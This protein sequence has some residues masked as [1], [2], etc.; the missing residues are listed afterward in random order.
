MR[1]KTGFQRSFFASWPT[2]TPATAP[3]IGS[4]LNLR[5]EQK[6][7]RSGLNKRRKNKERRSKRR[8]RR[9]SKFHFRKFF[10][11]LPSQSSNPTTNGSRR[12]RNRSG[13]YTSDLS[14]EQMTLSSRRVKWTRPYERIKLKN[15]NK[16]KKK[17]KKTQWPV[18]G[19]V[20]KGNM[21][22]DEA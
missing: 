4:K 18:K 22:N 12:E 16:K 19:N 21:N 7:E 10:T 8:R 1:R 2:L 9:R 5:R 15:N 11:F 14:T 3:K 17:W 13:R 20:I 6:N